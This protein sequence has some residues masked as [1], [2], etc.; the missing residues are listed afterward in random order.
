MKKV[1]LTLALAAFAFTANAQ[2]VIGGNIGFNHQGSHDDNYTAGV[3]AFTPTSNAYSTP[4]DVNT[5]FKIMP[6]VGY[7][8]N[9]KMQ[10]GIS[11]GIDYQYAKRWTAAASDDYASRTQMEWVF[12]PYFRYNV[13]TWKSF[14]VFCEASL[15]VGIHPKSKTTTV[16]GGTATDTDVPDNYTRFGIDIT[17]GL[18]YAFSENFSMDIYVNLANIYWNMY[19]YD[20]ASA[21][22]WGFGANA[23]AQTLQDHLGNF[24]IG[25]N[26]HF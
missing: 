5:A 11:L 26:Y 19:S 17:P 24:G 4:T 7:Q 1:L 25:F 10:V 14:N 21:H 20:G 13:F 12:A 2:F 3:P 16:V 22:E 18:N 9:D 6:K 8:L 15:T 23:S